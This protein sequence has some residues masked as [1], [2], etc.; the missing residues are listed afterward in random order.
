MILQKFNVNSDR[1][2]DHGNQSGPNALSGE[3]GVGYHQHYGRQTGGRQLR[4]HQL[5][6]EHGEE[7]G[8]LRH[9]HDHPCP[10]PQ[11]P[12]RPGLLTSGRLGRARRLRH[13]SVSDV[14]RFPVDGLGKSS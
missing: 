11:S 14:C 13:Y 5:R 10:H 1:F 4:L 9:Q 3:C 2:G 7:A 12:Q 6:A 8:L